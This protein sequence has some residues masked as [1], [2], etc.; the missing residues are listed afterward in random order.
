MTSDAE[1]FPAPVTYFQVGIPGVPYSA[2]RAP[3]G[4]NAD[5]MQQWAAWVA[6]C[7]R[8]V[9]DAFVEAFP[10]AASDVPARQ[11]T[12]AQPQRQQS[13]QQRETRDSK[14]PVVEGLTCDR[15]SGPVGRRA[16]TGRMRSDAAVCLGR[17]KDGQY[18]HT[19]AWLDE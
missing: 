1:P 8:I 19:V 10:E 13:A 11:V 16:A 4:V 17:C 3:L 9:R 12:P 5:E 7:A 14:Y 6:E 18:V 15:C 2:I